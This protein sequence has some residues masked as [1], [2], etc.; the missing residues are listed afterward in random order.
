MT[1]R[2]FLLFK[3]QPTK[4]PTAD[5]TYIPSMSPTQPLTARF[6]MELFGVARMI[7]NFQE[8]EL[9]LAITQSLEEFGIELGDIS[10]DY[11]AASGSNFYTE[12]ETQQHIIFHCKRYTEQR[13]ILRTQLRTV[14]NKY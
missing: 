10:L 8:Q 9:K 11:L 4:S 2:I 14:Y 3:F 12:F 1:Q 5:P 7:V 6:V 13:D